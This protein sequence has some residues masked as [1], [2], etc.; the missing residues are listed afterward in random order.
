MGLETKIN[1]SARSLTGFDGATM[2]TVGTIDLDVYS[3][4][5]IPYNGILDRPLISK[6]NAITSATHQKIWYLIP[7]GDDQAEEIFPEVSPEEG[8]KPEE[9]VELIPLDPDHPDRKALTT[10]LHNNKDIFAWSSSDMPGID[11][12]IICHQL[13]MNPAN[14]QWHRKDA[15]SL[16]R[17]SLS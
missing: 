12:N 3:P 5:V 1:K 13:H 9:D 7:W 2:V 4:L 15:T 17:G 10:F 14:N 6:I 11:P 8:W 16:P